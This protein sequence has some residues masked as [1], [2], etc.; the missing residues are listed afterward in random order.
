VGEL[1]ESYN[2]SVICSGADERAELHPDGGYE[3]RAG[4]KLTI[5]NSRESMGKIQLIKHPDRYNTQKP[6]TAKA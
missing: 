3:V 6:S 4:K 5:L 2:R 1:D